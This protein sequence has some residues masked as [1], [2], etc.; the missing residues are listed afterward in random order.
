MRRLVLGCS[1]SFSSSVNH[2]IAAVFWT[3]QDRHGLRFFR[4]ST[5][6]MARKKCRYGIVAVSWLGGKICE[7]SVIVQEIYSNVTTLTTSS[8][9][10]GTDALLNLQIASSPA[11]CNIP[12]AEKIEHQLYRQSSPKRQS[13]L[14]YCVPYKYLPSWPSSVQQFTRSI[15]AKLMKIMVRM[16]FLI[17]KILSISNA[18]P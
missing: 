3:Y 12:T 4:C 9:V 17:I 16:Q 11:G 13:W 8:T 15:P 1:C 10:V 7:I 5:N 14:T 18:K 6:I 2:F